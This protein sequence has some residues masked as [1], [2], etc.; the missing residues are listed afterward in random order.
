MAVPLSI[1]TKEVSREKLCFLFV[2][3]V[4][5]TNRSRAFQ[6]TPGHSRRNRRYDQH[7][8]NSHASLPRSNNQSGL[9]HSARPIYIRPHRQTRYGMEERFAFHFPVT[10][11]V[12]VF[13]FVDT[14]VE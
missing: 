2:L 12:V 1:C 13:L 10:S 7:R 4:P 6:L 14:L 5:L 3:S 8:F 11:G 9:S